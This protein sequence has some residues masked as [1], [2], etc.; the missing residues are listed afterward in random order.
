MVVKSTPGMS[1]PIPPIL[2]G[3]P[4]AFFPVP[5]PQTLFV[6]DAVPAPTACL[7]EPVASAVIDMATRP[8]IS[9]AIPTLCFFALIRFLLLGGT[10]QSWDGTQCIGAGGRSET[11]APP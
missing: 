9:N 6:A 8:P 11:V 10:C 7:L 1:I 3:L 2:I 5:A 4:V